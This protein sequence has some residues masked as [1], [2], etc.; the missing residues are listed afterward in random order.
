VVDEL[1]GLGYL[2]DRIA[3]ANRFET[4]VAI[5]ERIPDPSLV[6]V[7]VGDIFP[8]ALTASAAAGTTGGVVV[9]SGMDRSVAVTDKYLAA[10][11]DVPRFALGGPAARAYPSIAPV[12]GTDRFRTAAAIATTFFPAP[13]A[14]GFARGDVFADALTGGVHIAMRSGPILLTN[15]EGLH[16]AV[17]DYVSGHGDNLVAAYLYGGEK[18]LS[19]GVAVEVAGLVPSG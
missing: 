8:D 3:G 1:A 13:Y 16:P 12:F 6:L 9:F 15:P 2:V 14:A 18:S 4:A 17:P 10:H 19:P 5:A 7:A 11:S